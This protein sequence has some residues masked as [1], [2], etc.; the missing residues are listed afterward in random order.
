LNSSPLPS[1][2]LYREYLI[3]NHRALGVLASAEAREGSG[4]HTEPAHE[5]QGTPSGL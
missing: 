4:I 2:W 5:P 1:A 3:L